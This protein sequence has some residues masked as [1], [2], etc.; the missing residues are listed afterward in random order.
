MR[1]LLLDHLVEHYALYGDYSGVRT[2]RKHIGWYVRTLPDGE[3]FR[4]RMNAIEDCAEQLRAVG[5]YFDGL[6]DHMDRMPVQRPA[7]DDAPG[8]EE[9]AACAV[10]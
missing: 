8:E 5:D 7:D 6:A 1:R 9:E 3:V 4:A 10:H 2:A